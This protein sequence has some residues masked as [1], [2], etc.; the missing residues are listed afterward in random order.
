M[1]IDFRDRVMGGLC[2]QNSPV[3]AEENKNAQCVICLERKGDQSLKGERS[4]TTSS[5]RFYWVQLTQIHS[6]HIKLT[7]QCSRCYWRHL[8][9]IIEDTQGLSL[10][11]V[12]FSSS[13]CFIATGQSRSWR[14]Q[15][16][17]F[18]WPDSPPG[19]LCSN[20]IAATSWHSSQ[21]ETGRESKAAKRLWDFCRKTEDSG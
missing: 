14:K 2:P 1:F 6:T 4:W 11:R 20:K 17:L 15:C 16:I 8:Q 21:A 5:L 9:V 3:V 12:G 13:V 19:A 7:N 10:V 18:L